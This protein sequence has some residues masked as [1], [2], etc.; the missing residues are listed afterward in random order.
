MPV[1]P[2]KDVRNHRH[3][4]GTKNE[5]GAFLCKEFRTEGNY[6][7]ADH[8]TQEQ[9]WASL[10]HMKFWRRQRLRS[11]RTAVCVLNCVYVVLMSFAECAD[12]TQNGTVRDI[13][14][15]TRWPAHLFRYCSSRRKMKRAGRYGWF[16]A[17]QAQKRC[18][19]Q[20]LDTLEPGDVIGAAVIVHRTVRCV[21][22]WAAASARCCRLTVCRSAASAMPADRVQVGQKIFCAIKAATRRGVSC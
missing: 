5:K 16:P 19:E 6:R 14:V 1:S 15:L 7:N 21:L 20:Y 13:A 22:R 4:G 17:A 8:F 3:T 9:L 11:I 10:L 18:R 12:G 2:H